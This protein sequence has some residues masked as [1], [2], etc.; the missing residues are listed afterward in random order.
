MIVF[1]SK[2]FGCANFSGDLAP[3][4]CK[5]LFQCCDLPLFTAPRFMTAFLFLWRQKEKLVVDPTEFIHLP[6]RPPLFSTFFDFRAD[7]HPSPNS[8]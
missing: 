8:I 7:V 4:F 1:K 6:P 2:Q 3:R 5:N